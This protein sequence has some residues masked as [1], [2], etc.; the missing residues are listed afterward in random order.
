MVQ[1]LQFKSTKRKVRGLDVWIAYVKHQKFYEHTAAAAEIQKMIR[2][3]LGRCKA[4]AR[5]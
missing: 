2:G 5:Y 4:R 1:L 3:F